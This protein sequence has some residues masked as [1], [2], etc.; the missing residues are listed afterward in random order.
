[1]AQIDFTYIPG[2]SQIMLYFLRIARLEE[3]HARD[4]TISFCATYYSVV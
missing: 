1:M 4:H 3:N 2:V